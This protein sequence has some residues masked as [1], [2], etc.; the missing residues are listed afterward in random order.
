MAD[1]ESS[2]NALQRAEAKKNYLALA[3]MARTDRAV[4]AEFVLRD[5]T[6][7]HPIESAPLHIGWHEALDGHDRAVVITSVES[8]KALSL[9]TEIPVP[10][11]YTTMGELEVGDTVFARDGSPTVVEWV[12]PV[13][14][15]H[16]VYR[17]RLLDGSEVLADAE[18][19]W[20]AS[21]FRDDAMAC[22][23][24]RKPPGF[25]VVTTAEMA[26]CVRCSGQWNWRLPVAGVVE[27]PEV[28]LPVNPYVFGA[29]LGSGGG[30]DCCVDRLEKIGVVGNEHVPDLYLTAGPEQRLELLR[31][32]M[33]ASGSNSGG[34][35]VEITQKRRRLAENV[36]EIIRSLGMKA[37]MHEKVV[38][39][40]S[41]WTVSWTPTVQVFSLRR[42]SEV[43][44]PWLSAKRATWLNQRTVVAVD[45]V[46]SVPV[47][48]IG[49]AHE[50]HAFIAGRDHIVT[51]NS[52]QITIAR[53]LWALG[54]DPRAR[55]LVI[56]KRKEMAT[57]F[58]ASMRRLITK[59]DELHAVFPDLK[60]MVGGAWR[61]SEFIIDRG[62]G[63]G[64]PKDFSVQAAGVEGNVLGSRFTH[65]F[66]DDIL[67]FASTWTEHQREKTLSWL[68]SVVFGRLVTGSEVVFLANPWHAGDAAH[69][70]IK[71]YGWHEIRAGVIEEQIDSETFMGMGKAE[72]A[73]L[74]LTWPERWSL[75]RIEKFIRDF[76]AAEG[77]RQLF[78]ITPVEGSRIFREEW[79]QRC[80]ARGVG[81]DLLPSIE[82]ADMPP[83]SFIS[84]GVDL[85][86]R[87]G[88]RNDQ[89]CLFVF[90]VHPPPEDSELPHGDLR[91]LW[92]EMDKLGSPEI[93]RRILECNH[94]YPRAVFNVEDVGAQIYIAQDLCAE[95]PEVEVR[96]FS[97]QARSK[98]S[99]EYGLGGFA[100]QFERSRII[101]PSREVLDEDGDASYDVDPLVRTW[102]SELK[103]VSRTEHTG[104]AAMASMMA[105]EGARH[106]IFNHNWSV[107]LPDDGYDDLLPPGAGSWLP[108]S[109]VEL[110]GE[111]QAVRDVMDAEAEF[112]SVD[113]EDEAARVRAVADRFGFDLDGDDAV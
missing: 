61:E 100:N 6:T 70:L 84:I 104:D 110:S 60:P 53:A 102:I 36:L 55:I 43:L 16:V 64:D 75:E 29:W 67:D 65:V 4:F 66:I 101:I 39:E 45:E 20:V 49:V 80:M 3:K 85:A 105:R 38:S 35:R 89:T 14:T 1:A 95:H 11:G 7:G 10:G 59:S 46:G 47:R 77:D 12:G 73:K 54:K 5:E 24:G 37:A 8:G 108:P 17:V 107:S 94:R 50:S 19:Q 23:W 40:T 72:R 109:W 81:L 82:E 98:W 34:G 106:P 74:T 33:D 97:T 51:H 28:D 111:Q 41:S 76:G 26:E 32:L 42:K 83:D 99:N 63:G 93:K 86:S 58:T 57:K 52:Q 90:L 112:A 31:G 62:N 27:H 44:A 88:K 113:P 56:S 91:L 103:R 69:V 30:H 22:G 25:N 87:K 71:E 9:D 79:V 18:H 13:Y 68:Q 2:L 15:D 96:N 78:A 21:S 48:C 92:I